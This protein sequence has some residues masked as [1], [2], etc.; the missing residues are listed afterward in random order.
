MTATAHPTRSSSKPRGSVW[1]S[2]TL[3]ALTLRQML[4][5]R[6]VLLTAAVLLAPA[7]FAVYW[8]PTDPLAADELIL[9]GQIFV[10]GYLQFAAPF[11]ALITGT[12]LISVEKEERTLSYLVTRPVPRWLV[13]VMKYAAAAVFCGVGLVLSMTL[14]YLALAQ[15]F[16]MTKILEHWNPVIGV[17]GSAVA[18]MLVYLSIFLFL[19]MVARRPVVY[20]FIFVT[21]WEF[22][23]GLIPRSIR[24][25]TLVHYVRSLAT[26]AIEAAPEEHQFMLQGAMTDAAPMEVVLVV[27]P[28]VW[29]ALLAF[30]IWRFSTTEFHA[31]PDRR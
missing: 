9:W 21:V 12:S 18:G 22:F 11:V 14:S 16:G 1:A 3:F 15:H 29:I 10:I 5:T 7:A 24:Y 6:W 17:M 27:L 4:R 31:N 23:V 30:S 25:M 19:G 8:S 13:V 28:T 2:G 26:H 20:G